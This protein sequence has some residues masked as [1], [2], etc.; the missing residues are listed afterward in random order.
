VADGGDLGWKSHT[1]PKAKREQQRLKAELQLKAYALSGLDA[2]VP[3]EGDLALGWRWLVR[4]VAQH[5]IPMI[6]SNLSCGGEVLFPPSRVVQRE[7]VSI[8]FVG[9]LGEGM[10]PKPCT[11]ADPVSSVKAAVE[12]MG[13][14][15]QLVLLSHGKPQLDTDIASAVPEVGLVIS[16]HG[17]KTYPAPKLLSEG[18]VQLGA[19]SRGKKL[20][21]LT[22]GLVQGAVG[23]HIEAAEAEIQA[24]LKRQQD[25]SE[26][27]LKRIAESGDERLKERALTRQERL[28]REIAKLEAEL[29]AAQTPITSAEHRLTHDLHELSEDLA[30][31]PA[32]Q[33]LVTQTKAK[34]D[35][36][37]RAVV[38]AAAHSELNRLF[39]GSQ[40]CQGCHSEQH[41]QWK[42]TK[43]AYAWPTLQAVQ[44]SQDLE[45]W[46]CHVTG[47]MHP[48]GPKHPSQVK[49]GLENVGCESCHGP[50]AAHVA[51]GGAAK[52]VRA[53][54]ASVCTQCHDGVKDEG[55]FELESYMGR[56]EH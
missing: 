33:L 34:I 23:Y 41:A 5:E 35:A 3:G 19:G 36:V 55:R 54:S 37:E 18:A 25:R 50:G 30:D 22:V 27:N 16:G 44:R 12:A 56:V 2:M 49:G 29:K 21:V 52:M 13:E 10:A 26:R 38:P 51:A 47:A 14:V 45:C 4:Q 20:G 42:S 15:D 40:A 39:A 1:L 11:L 32:T 28:T 31:H 24:R 9:V 48:R 8:G 17:R 7:G 46:S 43:H 53:P 6:A